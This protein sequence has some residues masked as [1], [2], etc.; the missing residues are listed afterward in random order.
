MRISR[1]EQQEEEEGAHEEDQDLAVAA[2]DKVHHVKVVAECNASTGT[3][4]GPCHP[5]ATKRTSKAPQPRT[6]TQSASRLRR[7]RMPMAAAAASC[8]KTLHYN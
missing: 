5:K 4:S 8:R 6:R 1:L 7:K 3:M 2:V